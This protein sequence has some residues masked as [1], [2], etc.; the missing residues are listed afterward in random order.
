MGCV[1]AR[2]RGEVLLN[3]VTC[4]RAHVGMSVRAR[5]CLCIFVGMGVGVGVDACLLRVNIRELQP[6][7]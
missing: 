5:M 3:T 1:C 2:E 7:D 4:L 6:H